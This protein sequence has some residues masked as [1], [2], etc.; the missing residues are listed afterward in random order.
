MTDAASTFR[1]FESYL[2]IVQDLIEDDIQLILKQYNSKFVRYE[3]PPGNYSIKVI[4]EM[5]YGK[6]DHPGTLQLQNDDINMKKN[7]I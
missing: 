3:K 4:S 1:D 7:S 5:V 2:G 6:A